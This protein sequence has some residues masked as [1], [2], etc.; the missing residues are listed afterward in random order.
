[1]KWF[2]HLVDY[3]RQIHAGHVFPSFVQGDVSM[4]NFQINR[5]R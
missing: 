4:S 1:M 5:T 2:L 3:F